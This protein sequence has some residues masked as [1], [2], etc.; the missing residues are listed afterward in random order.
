[1]V[2]EEMKYPAH[3]CDW[4]YKKVP[5]DTEGNA[6][7]YALYDKGYEYGERVYVC[8]DCLVELL[9]DQQIADLKA[10][11]ERREKP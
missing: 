9:D 6:K 5:V 1:M 2:S 4:C 8:A 3:P 7:D 10:A 11:I